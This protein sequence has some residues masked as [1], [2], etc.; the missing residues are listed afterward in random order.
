MP[1]VLRS[2][3]L[4]VALV[5]LF[6]EPAGAAGG[7]TRGPAPEPI[8]VIAGEPLV[9]DGRLRRAHLGTSVDH[10]RVRAA[11]ARRRP[12]T[13]PWHRGARRLRQR[14]ALRR[15]PR[16]RQRARPDRRHPDAPRSA[17]ALGLG[18]GYRRLVLR[19]P[20]GLRVRG[21]PGWREARSVLFQRRAERRELGRGVGRG[22][23]AG[24]G[25]LARSFAFRSPNSASTTR[26]ADRSASRWCAKWAG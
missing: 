16:L 8:A 7:R 19:S 26:T 18:E 2:A 10:Q 21:Q 24:R 5:P 4:L 17:L 14:C 15:H 1:G 11:R 20:I 23:G 22:S 9:I 12:A 6:W 25:G 3:L 13:R